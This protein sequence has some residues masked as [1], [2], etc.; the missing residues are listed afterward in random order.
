MTRAIDGTRAQIAFYGSTPAYRGVLELHGWGELGDELHALSTS[1]R[2]DKWEAMSR[3]VDD[4]VLHTFAV[5]AEPARVAG[6]IRRRYGAL[7]DR[8]SFYT[9]YE[10]DAEVWEPIVQELRTSE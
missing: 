4:E 7:V 10:I 5:V 1:R 6:E 3:L 2:E 8:V 9:A